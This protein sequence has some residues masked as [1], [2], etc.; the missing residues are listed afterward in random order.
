MSRA[1]KQAVCG[2][3]QIPLLGL[4]TA[5]AGLAIAQTDTSGPAFEAASVK[6]SAPLPNGV[7]MI[8]M[9]GGPDSSDPGRITYTGVNLKALIAHAYGLKEFQVEGPAWLE[10]E[11]YDIIATIP[12]G[13]DKEQVGLMMQ[14]LLA[15]RFKLTLH[16][17]S[18][19]MAVYTLSVAKGGA[20]LQEVDPDAPLPPPP[21]GAPPPPPPP[22]GASGAPRGGG[23]RMMMSPA[24]RRF[25]GNTTVARLCDMLSNLT[26]RPVIDLTELKGTYAIDLSW[27]PD[28]NEKMGGKFGPAMAMATVQGGAPAPGAGQSGS[29]GPND[30]G[31]NLVQA[32]QSN[33]G[34][35]L[36]AKKNPADI[37]VI[38][39]AEKVPTEN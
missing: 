13:A 16:H 4:L 2:I 5:M 31:Q 6:V 1:R 8:R 39:H 34:L 30:P 7:M 17:E 32:L 35:K 26:D 25:T 18:K 33:Y 24:G 22:P 14:R 11:R 10:G 20:K 27:T 38:D 37:L 36:E 12:K 3:L 23:M 15:E 28:E 19:P 21:P 9:G 29:E